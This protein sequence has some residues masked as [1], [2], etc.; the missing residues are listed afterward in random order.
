M[1]HSKPFS[2]ACQNNRQPIL[3]RIKAVFTEPATILEIGTG[4]G[5]HAVYFAA[6]LSHLTWQPSDRPG[7]A[8]H[9]L[10][11]IQEA[12][13]ANIR[14]PL[15]LDVSLGSWPVDTIDGAYSANTAHIM[16]WE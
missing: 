7:G 1:V 9:S 3:E 15:E 16:S 5:Q 2:Q 8:G 6:E 12:A 10:G 13:L 4:T 11:W 14:P